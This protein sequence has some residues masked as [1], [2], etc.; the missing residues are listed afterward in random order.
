[1]EKQTQREKQSQL[2]NVGG[3][4]IDHPLIIFN[5]T[6][7][8]GKDQQMLKPLGKRLLRNYVFTVPRYYPSH[9]LIFVKGKKVLSQ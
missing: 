3:I 5:V 7:D 6:T 4:I 9:Y 1:M 2:I 8:S